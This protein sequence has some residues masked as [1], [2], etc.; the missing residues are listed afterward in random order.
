[1]VPAGII[2]LRNYNALAFRRFAD[3]RVT[4]R[5]LSIQAWRPVRFADSAGTWSGLACHH[6]RGLFAR[7][8]IATIGKYIVTVVPQ[9][10]ALS[11]VTVPPD[12]LAK[13]YT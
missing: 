11:I 2:S 8:S 10:T 7:A 6:W 9:P 4:R 3:A 1:M 13:P 5:L 12:C